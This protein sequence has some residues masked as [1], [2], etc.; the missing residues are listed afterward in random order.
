M[1]TTLYKSLTAKQRAALP[2]TYGV[3]VNAPYVLR[4]HEARK[5]QESSYDLDFLSVTEEFE[6]SLDIGLSNYGSG[7]ANWVIPEILKANSNTNKQAALWN[8]YISEV[9]GAGY[10][11]AQIKKAWNS[12]SKSQQ[13]FINSKIDE[14]LDNCLI[15]LMENR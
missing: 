13:S 2:E 5:K 3:P 10:T 11:P 14:Y 1:T 8:L 4:Q 6:I 12:Y 15:Q 9:V 7:R